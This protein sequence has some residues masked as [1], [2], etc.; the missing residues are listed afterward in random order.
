MQG[1]GFC[2][3]QHAHT[4]ILRIGQIDCHSFKYKGNNS[5]ASFTTTKH[6][7]TVITRLINTRTLC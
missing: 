4:L 7:A 1:N 3:G 5:N 2:F 6:R